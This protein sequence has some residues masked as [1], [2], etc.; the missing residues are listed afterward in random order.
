VTKEIED[1]NWVVMT[2][3]F[4]FMKWSMKNKQSVLCIFVVYSTYHCLQSLLHTSVP[5]F[6]WVWMQNLCLMW[7]SCVSLS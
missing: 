5:F 6:H 4:Y 1:Y 7:S 3:Q 2:V